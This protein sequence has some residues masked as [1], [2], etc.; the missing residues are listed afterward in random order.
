[1]YFCRKREGIENIAIHAAL[2]KTAACDRIKERERI[3]QGDFTKRQ[4][5]PDKPE[6]MLIS[7]K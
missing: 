7:P 2:K 3:F 5:A 1:L 4:N 6:F